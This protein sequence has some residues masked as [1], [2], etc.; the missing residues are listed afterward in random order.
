MTIS[1]VCC[2]GSGCC[3]VPISTAPPGITSSVPTASLVEMSVR[4]SNRPVAATPTTSAMP[5]GLS[6]DT[7][8]PMRTMSPLAGTRA[9]DQVPGA[10]QAPA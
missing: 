5:P 9:G 3:A 10:D 2:A 4:K 1:A 6:Y 8:W 7:S